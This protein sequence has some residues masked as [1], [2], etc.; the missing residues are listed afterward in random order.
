MYVYSETRR[1]QEQEQEDEKLAKEIAKQEEE[2][3][4]E[5]AKM[6]EEKSSTFPCPVCFSAV[7]VDPTAT[8]CGHI[9]CREC[10][11]KTIMVR[12]E[13]SH[14][15][16]VESV[17]LQTLLTDMNTLSLSLSLSLSVCLCVCVCVCVCVLTCTFIHIL[18]A[19]G[20]R[21][22]PSVQKSNA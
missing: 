18:Y 5:T 3:T 16:V 21:S 4:E 6:E 9:F 20:E 2:K 1:I 10:I 13:N 11:Q 12:S 15:G 14:G 19:D 22:M 7:I 8:K 17:I